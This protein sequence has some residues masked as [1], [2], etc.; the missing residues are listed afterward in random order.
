[1]P[2]RARGHSGLERTGSV[3]PRR[4][5]S[6]VQDSDT[7]FYHCL[8]SRAAQMHVAIKNPVQSL[9]SSVQ[10]GHSGQSERNGTSIRRVVTRRFLF[11]D[12][13]DLFIFSRAAS[14]RFRF[15][16]TSAFQ[17]LLLCVPVGASRSASR[18]PIIRQRS[19]PTIQGLRERGV[20]PIFFWLLRTHGQR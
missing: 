13:F 5:R 15:C 16:S 14:H 4:R 18:S 9:T 20:M 19:T 7:C 11:S 3:L 12:V 10:S 6:K 17:R 8:Q 1:M 2:C